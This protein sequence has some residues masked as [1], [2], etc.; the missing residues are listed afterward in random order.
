MTKRNTQFPATI[1]TGPLKTNQKVTEPETN[2]LA[3]FFRKSKL[4]LTL[5]SRGQW[6]PTNTL[7]LDNKGGLAIYSMN[8]SDDIKFRTGDA[9]MSGKNIY[10]V[11]KSCAPGIQKPEAIP[12]IDVDS[13]LLAIRIASYGPDFDFSVSVPGTTLTRIVQI[14][15]NQLLSDIATRTDSWD[16]E[17]N[18]EDETGQVLSLE[19]H[20]ITLSNLFAT[21]KNIY[22]QRRALTK[23]IDSEENIK[24]EGAFETS[25]NSLLI[26]SVPVFK[27]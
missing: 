19:L 9:T 27:F 22:I 4:S 26:Y 3:A 5:P 14:H 18:I 12:H 25:V 17:I 15:A 16:P 13:I 1:P 21:S 6:Y 2:P 24:D 20:P 23:N 8:A 10:E 11:I 7:T